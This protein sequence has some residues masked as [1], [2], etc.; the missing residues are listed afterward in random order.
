M[1]SCNVTGSELTKYGIVMAYVAMKS[2]NVTRS[3]LTKYGIVRPS[4]NVIGTVKDKYSFAKIE[5]ELHFC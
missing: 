4:C 3:E 5:D 1:T 2:C